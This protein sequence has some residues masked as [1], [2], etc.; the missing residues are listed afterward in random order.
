MGSFLKISKSSATDEWYTPKCL[1]ETI[2]PY[3][4]QFQKTWCPFDRKESNFVKVL[5]EHGFEVIRSHLSDGK[6][7]FTF[8]PEA[9]DVIVSNPPFSMRDKIL[10]R[11]FSLGKPFAVVGNSVGAFDG[12]M[13]HRLFKEH[14][15]E[16]LVPSA[17]TR[18][19][20]DYGRPEESQCRPPFQ[21]WF[22]CH[23]VLPEKIVFCNMGDG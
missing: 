22:F 15:V 11:L 23:K 19:F 3:L 12:K 14:G 6:D 17:R 4:T 9:Y 1:V 13:R 7:F 10:T 18:F 5:K 21:S 8:E 16:L 20:S 2:V